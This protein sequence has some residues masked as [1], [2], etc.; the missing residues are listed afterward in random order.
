MDLYKILDVE[1]NASADEIRKSYLKLSKKHHPDKGGDPEHFKKIQKAYDVLSDVQARDFYNMTGSIPGE[2]DGRGP[3]MHEMP[4]GF[5][6]DMGNIFGHMFGGVGGQRNG[7][8]Q[9]Q[10]KGPTKVQE[11]GLTLQQFYTGHK[12]DM[13]FERMKFCDS[14]KGSGASQKEMC[15]LCS[16]SGTQVQKVM[17]GP[18]IMS[19]TVP[20]GGCGGKGS[21]IKEKCGGCSGEGRISDNR[22][23]GIMIDAG[24][25]PGDVLIFENGCSDDPMFEKPGDIRIVLQEAVETTGWKRAGDT[26]EYEIR[27]SLGESLVGTTKKLLGH[28]RMPEGIYVNIPCA[29]VSGDVLVMK[30]E[31]MPIRGGGGRKGDARLR[32]I[33]VPSAEERQTIKD[34]CVQFIREKMGVKNEW[35]ISDAIDAVR[36]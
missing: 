33:V 32:V 12:L 34:S 4:G 30:G 5:P 11:I 15:G 36:T 16:G 3:V 2:D 10:A 24:M 23:V 6:F 21:I 22:Q 17:M 35:N 26:L 25:G 27:I 31:G 1:R 19:S 9:K 18:I 29:T 7:P 28:P 20:C 14:C 13:K 8:P